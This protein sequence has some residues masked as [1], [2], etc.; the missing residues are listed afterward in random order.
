MKMVDIWGDCPH[1]AIT[2]VGRP[3]G[4]RYICTKTYGTCNPNYCLGPDEDKKGESDEERE[5]T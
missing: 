3:R 1:K 4:W 2:K 5:D